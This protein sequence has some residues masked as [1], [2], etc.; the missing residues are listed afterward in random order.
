MARP[1]TISRIGIVGG[2]RLGGVLARRLCRFYRL[3]VHDRVDCVEADVAARCR[4]RRA[5]FP[6]LCAACE[7]V[8]LCVSA[9][10]VERLLSEAPASSPLFVSLATEL[11]H[12]AATR[13]PGVARRRLVAL[14][15]IGQFRAL[16]EG[17]PALFVTLH[18]GEA[19]L[20][21]LRQIFAT[22]GPIEIGD[23]RWVN[24]LNR[25]ATAAAL[26]LCEEFRTL[27]AGQ[28]VPHD[29]VDAALKG[30]LVG[31]VLDDPPARDNSYTSALLRQCPAPPGLAD[32]LEWVSRSAQTTPAGQAR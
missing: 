22:I 11:D 1:Q 30:V 17:L 25:T 21:V 26:R 8:L 7:V 6:D 2:G 29:W 16:E 3:D 31:T 19:E 32:W 12:E 13:R 20:A 10:E 5:S 15:L 28:N 9:L 4:A 14:K 24:T 23:D 18:R 27:F